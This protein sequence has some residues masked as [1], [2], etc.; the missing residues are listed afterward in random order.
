MSREREKLDR[1]LGGSLLRIL[2]VQEPA[3][4]RKS[5]SEL[6]GEMVARAVR[7]WKSKN[8][9]QVSEPIPGIPPPEPR[10]TIAISRQ[11]GTNAG[12]VAAELGQR[13]GWPVYDRQLL[14][15]I[16][17][18]LGLEPQTL[19]GL[20]ERRVSWFQE[21]LQSFSTAPV[22]SQ[23]GYVRHLVAALLSL[24]AEGNQ[25]IVGRGAAQILPPATTLRVRLV[26][27]VED[28]IAVLRER[29]GIGA[30]E[31]KLWLEVHDHDRHRFVMDHFHKNPDDDSLY[32]LI[33]NSSRFSPAACAEM[34]L[35]ALAQLRTARK[36]EPVQE[37]VSCAGA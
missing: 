12:L 9:P 25:V 31:A 34:I 10:F 15:R 37:G 22:A 5:S 13:L 8:Q 30:P 1:L 11:A 29:F 36:A 2:L 3:M 28:R 21:F 19:E 27:P 23:L 16:A 4:N 32:D 14:E 20:D 6:M 26:A 17:D 33:L 18:E 7:R 35:V 24:A